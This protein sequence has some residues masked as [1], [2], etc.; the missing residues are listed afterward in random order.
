M[1]S[2]M[3]PETTASALLE[4]HELQDEVFGAAGLVVR[5][6]DL[7]ELE[8]VIDALEGQLTVAMFVSDDD[9]ADARRLVPKLE[10]LA[11]RLLVNG[12]GTGVEVSPA[13]V[14]GGPYPATADGRST[15]VATL[16]IDRFLRPVSYQD[17]S[18]TLLP[19]VL[20]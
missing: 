12:F 8:A 7:A 9:E 19:E 10:M 6:R 20:R 11:G 5:C 3:T 1:S 2:T 16:A 18:C 15:S 4:H 13:M 17:F 14:H